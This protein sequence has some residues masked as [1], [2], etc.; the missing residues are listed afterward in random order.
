MRMI[1][2]CLCLL[3]T[4]SVTAGDKWQSLAPGMELG[5][6]AASRPSN[7][8]DSIITVLRIDPDLWELEFVGIS[9][10]G[11][12]GKRTAK[13]WSKVH[14]LTASINPGM[15]EMDHKTHIG[16]LRYRD[17]LIND[18]TN[19]YQ[20]VAVFDPRH[21][22][23]PRF[24]MFDLDDPEVT[25]KTILRDYATAVQNLRLIKRPGRNVWSQQEKMWSEAALG[26]D[27]SGR[28]LFIFCRSPFTMP[29]FNQELLRMGIGIVC[30]QHLEGGPEAQLYVN[31][32]DVEIELFGS[33]ETAFMENDGNAEPW[34]V[35][36]VIGV[37][38]RVSTA[39]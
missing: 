34:L 7:L 12:S 32:G 11:G 3:L 10:N 14:Q 28:I 33:Y 23:L 18:N 24:R 1:I 25:M 35:P 36:N 19:K 17:H 30:A 13:Q 4:S 26:E 27:E 20:S 5:T 39:K 9:C 37:R 22:G 6:F 38:P 29:D 31:V 21:D 2:F 8:G 15:F 16:Y